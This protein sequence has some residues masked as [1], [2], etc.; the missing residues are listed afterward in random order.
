MKSRFLKSLRVLFVEDE[1]RLL[2]LL[3]NAI[4]DNFSQFLLAKN[5]EE[6]L[7]IFEE[8]SVD[9]V[10]TDI[11]MPKKSGLEMAK[12]IKR[13]DASVPIIILSAFSDTQKLL[14]AIDVGV[15][16][17]LIKPFDPDELLDYIVSLR[18]YFEEPNTLLGENFYFNKV[19]KTLYKKQRYVPLNEKESMFIELLLI[20][21]EKNFHV[22]SDSLIMKTLWNEK[23][24]D[25]RLRTFIRRLR[26]KTSK[27]LIKNRKGEGYYLA[28]PPL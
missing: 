23:V 22:V 1:E 4:G 13:I 6:G 5:G 15:I 28:M 11:N 8:K 24:N 25:E 21:Y 9:I 7:K 3:K 10:I 27:E 16:K 12:A 17:Y 26:K 2:E 19:K 18:D 20:S 14:T